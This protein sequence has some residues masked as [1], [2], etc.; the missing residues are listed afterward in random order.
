LIRPIAAEIRSRITVIDNSGKVIADSGRSQKETLAM[1]NHLSRPEVREALNGGIGFDIHHSATL[2]IEMLYAA[3]PVRYGD[4]VIGAVR[5]ALPLTNV[6]QMLLKTD[7]IVML[8]SILAFLIAFALTIVIA[9]QVTGPIRAMIQIS[10]KFSEGDFSRRILRI[11]P[12]EI[13][14]LA[15]TLNGMAQDIEDRVR[16]IGTQNQKLA[17]VFDSMIEGVIVVDGATRIISVNKTVESIFG[18]SNTRAAGRALLETIRNNDLASVIDVALKNGTA[19]TAELDLVFPVRRIFEVNAT[20]IFDGKEIAGCVAVIHD[21]TC[22]RRLETMRKDFVANVSHELKTPL[23][24]IKGFVET[25][26]DGAIEDKENNRA[27]LSI[28]R[29]HADRLNG[30]VEDLLSLSHL[31][32]KEIALDKKDHDLKRLAED[33]LRGF[34]SQIKNKGIAF[35]D[36]LP[37]GLLVK[38]DGEKIKQVFT[39]LIDNAI[40]FNKEKG[41]IRVRAETPGDMVKVVVEDD[42]CGIPEKDTDRIFERFYRVDKAR[43]RDLGGTGLGLSI[44]K[45]IVELHGGLVGVES[46]VGLGSKFWFTLPKR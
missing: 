20:P 4:S 37:P 9:N 35:K 27:F 38:A 45:H 11:R 6:R 7:R 10:R 46:S 23:T 26:L 28:I 3:A 19:V 8:G 31:E 24:S 21:I 33:V 30:L 18:V 40:K 1:Q 29:E 5:L 43:S 16:Q 32:S 13:G 22:I 41:A 44:V 2:K 36:E 42:G 39:N 14:E 12:D 15:A 17:A 25:L 34:G